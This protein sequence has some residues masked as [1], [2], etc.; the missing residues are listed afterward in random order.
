MTI[1]SWISLKGL[2]DPQYQLC[3]SSSWIRFPL[4]SLPCCCCYSPVWVC[5]YAW[6]SLKQLCFD[7]LYFYTFL[8]L[9]Q[10]WRTKK[11][12]GFLVSSCLNCKEDCLHSLYLD[13]KG[14]IEY[15]AAC[16]W[17]RAA[18]WT[19]PQCEAAQKYEQNLPLINTK[20]S[21]HLESQTSKSSFFNVWGLLLP[22]LFLATMIADEESKWHF[23]SWHQLNCSHLQPCTWLYRFYFF[24]WKCWL[25]S[26]FVHWW[27]ILNVCWMCS[28][29][30]MNMIRNMQLLFKWIFATCKISYRIPAVQL[31]GALLHPAQ[32]L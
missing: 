9:K 6:T 14:S 23:T 10:N 31:L 8:M 30:S 28:S 20:P 27:D 7:V 18:S 22:R 11:I 16:W 21:F 32:L 19:F 3:A 17:Q 4:S 24:F 5:V 13:P 15:L 1:C 29:P 12:R 25:R 2:T 26:L